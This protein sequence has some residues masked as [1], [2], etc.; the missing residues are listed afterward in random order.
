M[1]NG[2]N[3][4][5][6]WFVDK[7]ATPSVYAWNLS[8]E[9]Q[10]PAN[11]ALQ[12]SYVGT[13]GL[14][15]PWER[16]MNQLTNAQRLEE[17]AS[18]TPTIP[19]DFTPYPQYAKDGMTGSYHDADSTY[20]AFQLAVQDKLGRSLNWSL[21]YTLAKSM[22]NSSM[23]PILTWGSF[24]GFGGNGVQDV[25]NL[26]ANWG[27]SAFDQR[28]SLGATFTYQLP[29]GYG[30]KFMNQGVASR[31]VGGWKVN[32]V[33]AASTGAPVDF[34]MNNNWLYGNNAEQR[35]NCVSGQGFKGSPRQSGTQIVGWWNSN[36]FA[37][38]GK[39]TLGN[40]PRD[41]G[42][43][44]GYQQVDLSAFKE[45]SFK[46][47]VNENTVLQFR[48]EAY[49]AMNRVNFNTPG[50]TVAN[51]GTTSPNFGVITSSVNGPRN[52]TAA[53]KLIF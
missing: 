31:V 3:G 19:N 52:M 17:E 6:I 24:A 16:G 47:P 22:D 48:V 20:H 25:Y 26:R 44:P 37:D 27:R 38:P 14:H 1:N 35:P 50:F 21:S 5:A 45:F 29:I 9:R 42:S 4:G 13:R 12:A 7:T 34:T 28:Q 51:D 46:T 33:V 15:L 41:V 49:N 39:Y 11:I 18:A 40:C 23:N 53:L 32:A 2:A 43:G 30:Q 36:A 10:L 8:I